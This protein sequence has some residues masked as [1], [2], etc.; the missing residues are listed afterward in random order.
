ML[1][2]ASVAFFA[3]TSLTP[4]AQAQQ[5]EDGIIER[6]SPSPVRALNSKVLFGPVANTA[7]DQRFLAFFEGAP[8]PVRQGFLAGGTLNNG[9]FNN[10]TGAT[11]ILFGR[12]HDFWFQPNPTR[13]VAF[14]GFDATERDRYFSAGFKR[15]IQGHLGAPGFRFM[16]TFGAKIR[17]FDPATGT[18]ENRLNALRVLGGHEWHL[19]S[20]TV[21]IMAGGSFTLNSSDAA[22][23]TRRMG[24][25]GPVGMLD[26]WQDWG[27]PDGR[28][29][30]RYTAL[31]AMADQTSR[32]THIRLRHGFQFAEHP[33]R[34]G[35]E[36]AYSTGE[37]QSRRGVPLQGGWRKARLGI[38]LSEIPFRAIRLAVSGGVEWRHDHKPGA[39][40]HLATYVRY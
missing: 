22:Q 4:S 34:I 40:M 10:S 13:N 21:G 7:E 19:A 32:S 31:F 12:N 1:R 6:P 38:H 9:R 3:L 18:R 33:W 29:G 8:P 25:F 5:N 35:P 36:V 15:A 26:L 28:W 16:A 37:R 17:D 2:G 11:K 14:I 27:K 23:K 39:Y 30:S 20:L 24:R